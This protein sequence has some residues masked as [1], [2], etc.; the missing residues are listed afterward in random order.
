MTEEQRQQAIR[1]IRAKRGF[2]VHSAIYLTVIASLF[3]IWAMTSA[4]YPWPIWPTLGWGIGVIAHGASVYLWRS[5][6]S[7]A[8]IDRELQR[9][10]RS[11][12]STSTGR[13]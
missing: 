12:T 2:W 4:T 5:E 9:Q 6:I 8:A 7:E 1:R 3:V 11:T 13:G 10:G